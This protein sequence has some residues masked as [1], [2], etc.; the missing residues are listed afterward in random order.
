MSFEWKKHGRP[1]ETK[2]MLQ[3][4]QGWLTETVCINFEMRKLGWTTATK[5]QEHKG[6]NE[7]DIYDS[8]HFYAPTKVKGKNLK[9]K[10]IPEFRELTKSAN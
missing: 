7:N 5:K 1:D 8:A 9:T 4:F 2:K 10:T 6:R 3:K